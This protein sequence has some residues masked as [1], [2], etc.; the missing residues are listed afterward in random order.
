MSSAACRPL[1]ASACA[2][3]RQHTLCILSGDF[4]R[5]AGWQWHRMLT[6]SL[7]TSAWRAWSVV[8][9]LVCEEV[10]RLLASELRDHRPV[11]APRLAGPEMLPGLCRRALDLV[12]ALV[13]ESNI[14]SLTKEL[15]PGLCRRALDLVYAL[16]NE[17]NIQSLTK[18]L[19]PGLCRRALDL[20]YA[21]VNESNI[22][23]LTKE[24]LPGLCRRALDLVYALVNENN[25]QSLARELLDYLSDW[26]GLSCCLGCAGGPWT[27][28]MRW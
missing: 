16:V 11:R 2:A 3:P 27:W 6:P 24:L 20:V 12:Y 22:Q 23:S 10:M 4:P 14:Q 26:R 7:A 18:E 17:S 21:L 19:L 28:C 1:P 5:A 8:S 15:L 25:I 13:N 9:T